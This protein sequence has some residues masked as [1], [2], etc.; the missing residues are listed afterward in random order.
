MF[1]ALKKS[2]RVCVS[3]INL[4]QLGWSHR[5]PMGQ[6]CRSSVERTSPLEM[7]TQV[8]LQG[9]RSWLWPWPRSSQASAPAS[10]RDGWSR[11]ILQRSEPDHESNVHEDSMNYPWRPVGPANPDIVF[12]LG[13]VRYLFSLFL[14]PWPLRA[15]VVNFSGISYEIPL[16]RS[17]DETNLPWTTP[18]P[19]FSLPKL[20]WALDSLKFMVLSFLKRPRRPTYV[21]PRTGREKKE[22]EGESLKGEAL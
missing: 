19:R 15:W 3:R 18:P 6:R 5:D 11:A 20:W 4:D 9:L 21:G 16:Q 7:C 22:K 1:W 12:L 14:L 8:R 10:S 2:V 17:G 13:E